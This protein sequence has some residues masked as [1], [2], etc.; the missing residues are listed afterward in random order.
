MLEEESLFD[1]YTKLCDIANES[2]TLGE[3]IPEFVIVRKIIRSI[4]DKFQP[5]TTAMEKSKNLDTT[6]VEELIGSFYA[7]EMNLKQSKKRRRPLLSNQPKK[8]QKRWSLMEMMKKTSLPY[9]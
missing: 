9:S 6:E 4:P 5:K 8:R 1:F 2:F 7:F 3:K